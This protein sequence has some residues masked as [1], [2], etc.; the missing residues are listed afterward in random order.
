MTDFLVIL[1]FIIV[2][3]L[4]VVVTVRTFRYKKSYTAA[5]RMAFIFGTIAVTAYTITLVSYDYFW[6]KMFSAILFASMFCSDYAPAVLNI[7]H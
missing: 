4:T 7:L 3:L 5:C 1:P 6:G 2:I